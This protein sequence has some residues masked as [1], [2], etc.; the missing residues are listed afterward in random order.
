MA[1][2]KASRFNWKTLSITACMVLVIALLAAC[3]GGND[4][5][6]SNTNSNSGGNN[7]SGQSGNNQSQ[8]QN[9]SEN[10]NEEGAGGEEVGYPDELT[11]W[12]DMNVNVEATLLDHNEMGVYKGIQ[13]ATGTE[14]SWLHPSGDGAQ[15]LEQFNLLLAS[16]NL[17][18][19]IEFN[20]VTVDRG[21]DGA[22]NN[23]TILRLNELIEEHAPNLTAYMDANPQIKKM[24]TTDEGNMFGFPFLRGHDNLMVYHGP[25]IRQDW[26]DKLNLEMPTT[27]DEW[28]T[29]LT[30]FK[31]NNNGAAPFVLRLNQMR[32]GMTVL[33]AF[34]IPLEFYQ[35]NGAVKYG[36]ME[37][38]FKDFLTLMNKWYEQGLLDPDFAAMD[39]TL[40]DAKVTNS[41]LLVFP[42]NAGAG[43]GKYMGLMR[44]DPE[45][46]LAG[47]PYPVLNKGDTPLWGQKDYPY[48]GLTAAITTAAENPEQVVKWLDFAYGEEGHNLMNFGVEGES[49]TMVDGYPTYTETM[50]NHPDG[51]PLNQALSQYVRSTHG[52]PFVQDIRYFEQYMELPE[53]LA[54]VEVWSQPT[55]EM[56]MPLVTP[57]AEESRQYSSIMSDLNVYREEMTIKFIMGS[58]PLDN[59]DQYVETLK[60]MGIEQAISIQQAALERYNAR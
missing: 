57:T 29:V 56:K 14:V 38:G 4:G 51:L 50:Y 20:W 5:G 43:I 23:G 46:Q 54:A 11:Y 9:Q 2:S 8:N 30:T 24:V 25:I 59:F 26:L 53:Q 35:D 16:R 44:D 19:V 3:S 32:E 15:V 34:G 33:G 22:I 10:N 36:S 7:N 58:E 39:D 28:E 55:N 41:Q 1:Q 13:E 40:L 18:D 27:I 49:Y 37:P 52:G 45:F 31:E 42:G 21:P 60:A 17:P 6:N 48:P 12:V 47:A